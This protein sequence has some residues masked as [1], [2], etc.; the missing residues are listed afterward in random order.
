[1]NQINAVEYVPIAR[2]YEM[3]RNNP[4]KK[5]A[6]ATKPERL[7][8]GRWVIGLLKWPF[9][10]K[11]RTAERCYMLLSLRTCAPRKSIIMSFPFEKNGPTAQDS[12]NKK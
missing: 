7:S 12:A 4:I 9:I 1:M 6:T 11:F 8:K 3:N 2:G 10:F 5:E